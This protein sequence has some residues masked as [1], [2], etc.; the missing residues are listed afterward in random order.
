LEV[1]FLTRQAPCKLITILSK[2]YFPQRHILHSCNVGFLCIFASPQHRKCQRQKNRKWHR[3]IRPQHSTK[4]G[5]REPFALYDDGRKTRSDL[6]SKS[7][8]RPAQ[9]RAPR[10][11]KCPKI[12]QSFGKRPAESRAPKVKIYLVH[13][14]KT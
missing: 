8:K 3:N 7:W 13:P 5:K 10:R 4:N 11:S 6:S 2:E 1:R 9:S 12:G 14:A